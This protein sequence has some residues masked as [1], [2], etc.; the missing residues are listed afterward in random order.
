MTC[1]HLLIRRHI[2]SLIILY[3]C[4]FLNSCCKNNRERDEVKYM[5]GK[6]IEFPKDYELLNKS[7][8]E[9]IERCLGKC[10][11]IVVYVD[12]RMPCA[13][14]FAE[15]ISHWQKTSR[16]ISNNKLPFVVILAGEQNKEIWDQCKCMS[17]NTPFVFYSSSIFAKE[18]NIEN[19][20]ARH[21]TFLLNDNNEIILVGEF[22]KSEKMQQLYRKAITKMNKV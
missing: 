17:V 13:E 10:A 5:L 7:N 11:K 21:K 3:A 6:C 18:N 2:C 4:V 1:L 9:S 22:F 12:Y 20:L 8:R 14:C 15:T 19:I 16:L